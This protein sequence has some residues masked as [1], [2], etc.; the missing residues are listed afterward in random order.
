M[1]FKRKKARTDIVTARFLEI[2]N[3]DGAIMKCL[4][5][6]GSMEKEEK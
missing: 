2:I 3:Q 5:E 6:N 4:M 1:D